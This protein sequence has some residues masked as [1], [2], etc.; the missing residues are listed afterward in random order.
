MRPRDRLI[1]VLSTLFVNFVATTHAAEEP[2]RPW[3]SPSSPEAEFGHGLTENQA[4]NGWI[5]LFDG[6]SDFG[7]LG[8]KIENGKLEGGKTTTHFGS[9]QLSGHAVRGGKLMVGGIEFTVLKGDFRLGLNWDAS[10]PLKLGEV[11][12]SRLILRPLGMKS[13]FNN[14]DLEGWQIIRRTNVP[15]ER[16]TKWEVV[17]GLI[18]AVGGPGALELQ[19]QFGDLVLQIDVRTR[20]KLVN[21]GLFFRAIPGDFMNGYEAQI[22]NAC[23]DHDPAQPVRYSTGGIDDRQLA[24]RL[25]SRDKQKFT[26]TVIAHGPHIATWVNGFQMTDWTDKRQPHEN[27]RRGLRTKPGT[28][29]LQA[30][31]PGTDLEF[32][33]IRVMSLQR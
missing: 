29:Q 22:F 28:I 27:P 2:K 19:Q 24:R 10:G 18:T 3:T 20:D 32:S 33:N 1:V 12:V 4:R 7:W 13:V 15:K 6:K 31:D 25:V 23:Y 8:S 30:H 26:M 9:W 5:S 14:K 16:Q 17:G 11:A 21:G